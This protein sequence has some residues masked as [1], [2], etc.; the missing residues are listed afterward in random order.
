MLTS[1]PTKVLQTNSMPS[2]RRYSIFSSRISFSILKFGMPYSRTP[3]GSG[4]ESSTVT[5]WPFF[6]SSSATARP[7]GPAPTTAATPAPHDGGPPA[8]RVGQAV[9]VVAAVVAVMIGH[10]RLQPADSD[11]KR[12]LAD[13]AVTFAEAL[14][15]AEAA[16][17]LGQGGGLGG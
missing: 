11:R 6:A 3:P 13:D 4:Q 8:R 7:A 2:L 10:K 14:L 9:P 5:A 16:A 1:L 17:H 15:R 12:L